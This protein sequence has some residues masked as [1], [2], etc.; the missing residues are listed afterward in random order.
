MT[1]P[2]QAV[3]QKHQTPFYRVIKGLDYIYIIRGLTLVATV[4]LAFG[5]LMISVMAADKNPLMASGV[6]AI[7]IL[8]VG[9]LAIS[10][11][12]P[13]RLTR[14]LPVSGDMRLLLSGLPVCFGFLLCIYLFAGPR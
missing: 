5:A 2:E 6:L 13:D 1:G 11:I 4:P 3:A 12:A 10:A 9:I 8:L 14:R 7:G